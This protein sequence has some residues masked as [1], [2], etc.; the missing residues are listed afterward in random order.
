MPPQRVVL[1]R[2]GRDGQVR[3]VSEPLG[4]VFAPVPEKG[5]RPAYSYGPEHDRQLVFQ[6]PVSVVPAEV[7][8]LLTLWWHCRLNKVLP[9]AGGWSDQPLTVR[10]GFPVFEAEMH[11]VERHEGQHGSVQ[12]ATLALGALFGA[13]SR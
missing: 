3:D 5:Q 4:G 10:R 13:T 6:C 11:G 2:R 7:W 8:T 1:Q 9:V 12:A